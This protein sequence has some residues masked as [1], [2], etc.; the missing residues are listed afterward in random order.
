MP[1][2]N[3]WPARPAE[4]LEQQPGQVGA[5]HDQGRESC[6]SSASVAA[7]P[8]ELTCDGQGV[9]EEDCCAKRELAEHQGRHAVI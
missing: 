3:R 8:V 7:V 4:S 5:L 2:I 6:A 1:F 9:E